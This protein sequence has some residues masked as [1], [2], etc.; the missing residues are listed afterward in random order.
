MDNGCAVMRDRHPVRSARPIQTVST[1]QCSGAV[2][3]PCYASQAEFIGFSVVFKST[4]HEHA[5]LLSSQESTDFC[6]RGVLTWA[7]ASVSMTPKTTVHVLFFANVLPCPLF[8]ASPE[9]RDA[10]QSMIFTRLQRQSP[11]GKC[12]HTMQIPPPD[13]RRLQYLCDFE[14]KC[15]VPIA[16]TRLSQMAWRQISSAVPHEQVSRA[17]TWAGPDLRKRTGLAMERSPG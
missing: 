13:S 8:R 9:L 16:N 10:Q 11:P 14:D 1:P 6:S 17:W 12:H 15:Y 4:V 5:R 2:G 3:R 7:A